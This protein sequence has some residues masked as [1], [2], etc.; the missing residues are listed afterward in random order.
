MMRSFKSILVPLSAV[1][2]T[3]ELGF[4][5]NS[6]VY[7]VGAE[8]NDVALS[9][10]EDVQENPEG[11]SESSQEV[12]VFGEG[13]NKFEGP[14]FGEFPSVDFRHL[15]A[16]V[17]E[18]MRAFSG[19]GVEPFGR[20]FF[21][22][23]PGSPA[24]P[25]LR[26]AKPKTSLKRVGACRYVISWMQ[27]VTANNVRV[28]LHLQSRQVEVQYRACT[29]HDEKTEHGES[30]S[31]SREQ[32]SQSVSVDPECIMTREVVAQKLAGW[33]D[34]GE[35]V[36]PGSPKKLLITFPSPEHINQL[37]KEGH[38]PEGALEKVKGGD[39]SDFTPTQMCLLS[40][41]TPHECALAEGQQVEL[42]ETPLPSSPSTPDSVDLPRFS[43]HNGEI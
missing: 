36:P 15:Y 6:H 35:S 2:A 8:T 38:V 28:V 24:F 25:R 39:F 3:A 1:V 20:P 19:L 37:I 26:I 22:E 4:L 13:W 30:H 9:L 18:M 29:R 33:A 11:H 34:N 32:S 16:Q 43:N 17:Q 40:G 42:E 7:V 12:D 41:R 5:P 10:P 23:S 31:E 14:G 27:G 21:G